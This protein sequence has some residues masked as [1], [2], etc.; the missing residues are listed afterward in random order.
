METVDL[1]S[2]LGEGF[3]HW[4]LGDDTALL[5]VV[6]SANIACGY[7]AGDPEIMEAV[8]REAAAAG[9]SIGAQVGYRDLAGFGRRFIDVA[10][11]TLRAE[12][13]SQIAAL[14]AFAR[15]AGSAVSY[16]K[17]HGALYN[18]VVTH[19]EQAA[20]LADAVA[21]LSPGSAVLGLPGSAWL[22]HAEGRGLQP[23]AEAFAD[24]AYTPQGHLVARS[25]AG[26]VL[27]DPDLIARRT[28]A[29]ATGEPIA[30]I[31]GDP[32]VVK[33]QSI[34]VHGDTPGAVRIAGQVRLA[35]ETA[36]I[37]VSAFAGG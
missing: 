3:G 34:C 30:D 25:H 4:T 2:D 13:I 16:V 15:L 1:N 32:L 33:A 20:A 7:H 9:V 10:A 35:L 21:D 29:I 11:A 14:D 24:R 12:T 18:A 23:V 28:V 37:E 5:T 17:P 36:G 6:T 8:C 26:A 31:N 19:E 27:H 22:R